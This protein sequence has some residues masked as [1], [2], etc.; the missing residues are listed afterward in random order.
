ME[1]YLI[2]LNALMVIDTC[3]HLTDLHNKREATKA[4]PYY[5]VP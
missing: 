3:D 2:K 1:I 4:N 5:Q